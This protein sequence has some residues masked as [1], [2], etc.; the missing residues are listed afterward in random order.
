VTAA[1]KD[2]ADELKSNLPPAVAFFLLF[3]FAL[4]LVAFRSLVVAI[5]AILLNLLYVAVAYGVLV[6]V[7][8][9]GVGKACSASAPRTGSRRSCRCCCS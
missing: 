2:Q 8:Q 5:K 6:L 9:H 1:W 4:M 3:A 7:F